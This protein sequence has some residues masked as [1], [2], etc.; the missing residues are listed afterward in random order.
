MFTI[1][2][3]KLAKLEKAAER[4]E[5]KDERAERVYL[6]EET[7]ELKRAEAKTE[8][9][10]AEEMKFYKYEKEY[11]KAVAKEKEEEAELKSVEELEAKMGISSGKTSKKILYEFI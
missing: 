8:A 2:R 4:K 6:A 7:Q 9:A 3:Q 5:K 1:V 10:L 11:E